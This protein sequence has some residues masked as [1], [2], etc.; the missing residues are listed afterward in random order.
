MGIQ[1]SVYISWQKR[2]LSFGGLIV[3]EFY[4][5]GRLEKRILT[6]KSLTFC[7]FELMLDIKRCKPDLRA[8]LTLAIQRDSLK[9]VYNLLH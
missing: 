1:K 4:K 5:F 3:N 8:L 6:E 2:I 9:C 7:I